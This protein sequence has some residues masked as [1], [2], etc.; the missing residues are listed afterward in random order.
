[1]NKISKIGIATSKCIA[2]PLDDVRNNIGLGL[3]INRFIALIIKPALDQQKRKK[4]QCAIIELFPNNQKPRVHFN[5]NTVFAFEFK[6][7][8]VINK[9]SIGKTFTQLGLK[10]EDM[11]DIRIPDDFGDPNSAKALIIRMDPYFYLFFDFRYNRARVKVQLETAKEF[12]S[13]A[14]KL[15]PKKELS[16]ICESL[17]SAIELISQ[18]ILLSMPN[19]KKGKA[20]DKFDR[21]NKVKK[22]L[23]VVSDD[24]MKTFDT[25]NKARRLARYP[26]FSKD[27]KHQNIKTFLTPKMITDALEKLENELENNII[28]KI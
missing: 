3:T 24:F 28:I 20:H 27:P 7:K 18:A 13:A 26:D 5:E 22:D 2:V 11:N 21:L 9:D 8:N 25:F 14:K 4:F 15:D 23:Q 16:P 10:I 17:W 1:M 6:K 19:E 12:V